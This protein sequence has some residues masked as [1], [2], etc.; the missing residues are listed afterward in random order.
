ME[1]LNNWVNRSWYLVDIDFIEKGGSVA[2]CSSN[3]SS[4]SSGSNSSGKKMKIPTHIMEEKLKKLMKYQIQTKDYTQAAKLAL[5]YPFMRSRLFEKLDSIDEI[6]SCLELE[7][8]KKF[9][10]VENLKFADISMV[11][12]IET[13]YFTSDHYPNFI[14]EN[15]EKILS[16]FFW[17][18]DH[19]KKQNY[20]DDLLLLNFVYLDVILINIDLNKSSPE[21]LWGSLCFLLDCILDS[22]IVEK[23]KKRSAQYRLNK[24]LNVEKRLSPKQLWIHFLNIL[25]N[26]LKQS[27]KAKYD[28]IKCS[29]SDDVY[30][31]A[32][33]ML[34]LVTNNSDLRNFVG[35]VSL[36]AIFLFNLISSLFEDFDSKNSDHINSSFFDL[37]LLNK[38]DSDKKMNAKKN[39]SLQSINKFL[40][41]A[42]E[43]I[44]FLKV[45]NTFNDELKQMT[46]KYWVLN[47]ALFNVYL[48]GNHERALKNVFAMLSDKAIASMGVSYKLMKLQLSKYNYLERYDTFVEILTKVGD[49]DNFDDEAHFTDIFSSKI[50]FE[51]E[52]SETSLY[53]SIKLNV[54]NLLNLLLL[55]LGNIFFDPKYYSY[56][57]TE[58]IQCL[59]IHALIMSQYFTN[60]PINFETLV[61][62]LSEDFPSTITEYVEHIFDINL[63]EKITC[64]YQNN[65]DIIECIL[66]NANNIYVSN[67]LLAA[68]KFLKSNIS[69]I[70]TIISNF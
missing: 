41:D 40:L 56:S 5:K 25:L 33:S 7:Y 13:I 63:M 61:D 4:L 26:S 17:Y 24:Y 22:D 60:T 19:T 39:K 50:D 55:F 62:N 3:A 45:S 42:A 69:K 12:Y 30:E 64:K 34:D 35:Y 29:N 11:K 46:N 57:S 43:C 58:E 52:L 37:Q 36:F 54:P 66:N 32:T 48:I 38:G 53:K 1:D 67:H 49:T 47:I 23:I 44:K 18:K 70:R 59:N 16:H 27:S 28:P 14:E 6:I 51:K 9:I 8:L 68:A 21:A 10:L 31:I 65:K 15:I 20:A 2:D